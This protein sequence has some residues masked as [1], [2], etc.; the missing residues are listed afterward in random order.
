LFSSWLYG[1]V[2]RDD[3]DG[4]IRTDDATQAAQDTIFRTNLF[5]DIVAL[6]VQGL[7]DGKR[8]LGAGINAQPAGL[9]TLGANNMLFIFG[10]HILTPQR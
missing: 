4:D 9:A 1:L 7:T 5:N 6:T 2:Q 8:I 10:F 3:A